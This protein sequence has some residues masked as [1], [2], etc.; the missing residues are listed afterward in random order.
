MAKLKKGTTIDNRDIIQEFDSFRQEYK[1][2]K[3][4]RNNPHNVTTQQIGAVPTS[5]TITAGSGL[6]GGGNLGANRTLS[7]DST[8]VRTSGNQNIEGHKHFE[9]ISFIRAN[10]TTYASIRSHNY[11]FDL[12]SDYGYRVINVHGEEVFAARNNIG[13]NNY[14]SIRLEGLEE[15]VTSSSPNLY[16]T[17]AFN[18]QRTTSSKKYKMNIR[19]I[20]EIED[21]NYF[22][23]ILNLVPKGWHD[24]NAVEEYAEHL[25]CL[26]QGIE[27]N[28]E[29]DVCF[30]LE[31]YYGLIAEDL[32]EVG[33]ERF[34]N[35]RI[36]DG[37]KIVE[38]IQYDKLWTLLIPI[39]KEL[40]QK[41]EELEEKLKGEAHAN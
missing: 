20:E 17:S 16:I 2:H 9:E 27:S 15:Y 7:V 38:G 31:R 36:K 3:N 29:N 28:Y 32:E 19:P 4:N 12:Y 33:L 10:L 18:V 34:L 21:E 35:Y 11:Y 24:K 8:V 41:V 25:T 23:R 39:I 6:T 26:E 14:R 1:S 30:P 37:E 22:E 13:T 40:K 5:R